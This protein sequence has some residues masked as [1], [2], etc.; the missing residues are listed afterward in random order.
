M[1]V[2]HRVNQRQRNFAFLQVA[3]NR[4]AELLRGGGEIEK[5]VDQLERQPGVLAVVGERLLF[6]FAQTAKHRAK[7]RAAAEQARRFVGGQAQR[8]FLGYVD[9]ANFFELNQLAFDHFLRQVDKDV[10]NAEIALFE[11]HLEGLHVEPIASEDAAVIAPLCIGGGPAAA[12]ARAVDHVV[13]DKR[14]AVKQLDDRG[15][16]NGAAVA[17]AGIFRGKQQKRWTQSLATAAQQVGGNF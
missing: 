1:P 10:E 6:L 7:A 16:A 8:I 9:T 4:L 13:V 14:S 5:I 11:G 12:R 15:K 2:L 17:A 3:K